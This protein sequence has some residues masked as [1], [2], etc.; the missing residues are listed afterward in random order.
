M[1]LINI[2]SCHKDASLKMYLLISHL[3]SA[4]SSPSFPSPPLILL[5]FFERSEDC[6]I[7]PQNHWL[8]SSFILKHLTWGIQTKVD[9]VPL[10]KICSCVC[11]SSWIL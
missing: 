3:K 4:V 8:R 5:I 11:C 1:W 2:I 7:T 6:I 10:H 9:N